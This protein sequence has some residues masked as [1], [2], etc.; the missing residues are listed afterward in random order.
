LSDDSRSARADGSTRTPVAVV[1]GGASG[2]GAAT[3]RRL[4]EDGCHVVV[5]DIDG[6]HAAEVATALPSVS[7]AVR[8]DVSAEV[9][10]EGYMKA[11]IAAFGRVDRVFL[12]AGVGRATSLIEETVE[13]FDRIIRVN[14]R[15]VFLGLRSAL[16]VMREQ[17][18][19]GAI[20]V[21][22]S[23]AALSGS[24]LASYSAAKHGAWGL[25]RTAA[26]EGATFGVRV[27]AVAPGSIDTPMMRA[28]ETRLGG[29]PAAA[30]AL[31][32][33]TPLGRH[34]D[35]YGSPEELANVV[36]FLL[37]DASGWVTGVAV[38]VDGGVLVADPYRLPGVGR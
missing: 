1:T 19:G 26:I 24:D 2:I 6:E 31:H 7:L 38:P 29:G 12:N 20:V 33:T 30:Q 34:H 23:T 27:N 18:Q 8:A 14:L 9:D 35:R 4:A 36:A 3:A 22:T 37:G 10:V 13:D 15:S 16:R 25:V 5:V 11:A 17:A 21:T 32:A 28:L